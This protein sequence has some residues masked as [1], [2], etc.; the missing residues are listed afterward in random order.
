MTVAVY[1]CSVGE[2]IKVC[3]GI[4]AQSFLDG[5]RPI[6]PDVSRIIEQPFEPL[7]HSRRLYSNV[8]QLRPQNEVEAMIVRYKDLIWSVTT[9]VG[10]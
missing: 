9:S 6:A 7:L 10:L 8:S 5:V 2:H 1:L 3:N 4:F